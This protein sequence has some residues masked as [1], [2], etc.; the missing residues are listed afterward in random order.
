MNHLHEALV[1]IKQDF[2]LQ[3]GATA[4]ATAR[5]PPCCT[6]E[7]SLTPDPGLIG[8]PASFKIN[9]ILSKCLPPCIF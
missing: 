3:L 4:Y 1:N 2:P 9:G 5:S 8:T 6:A 7:V